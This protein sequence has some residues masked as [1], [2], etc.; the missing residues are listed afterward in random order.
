MFCN[1]QIYLLI[2]IFLQVVS[3]QMTDMSEYLSIDSIDYMIP[4]EGGV[5][6]LKKENIDSCL[7]VWTLNESCESICLNFLH[8]KS[9]SFDGGW[10]TLSTEKDHNSIHLSFNLNHSNDNRLLKLE[11][12]NDEEIK[13]LKG[14]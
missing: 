7:I 12:K 6:D 4:A 11:I 3:C 1:K 9:A 5:I 2:I 13:K 10:F 8:E 14:E